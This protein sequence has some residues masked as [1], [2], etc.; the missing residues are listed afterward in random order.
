M[1]K[2]IQQLIEM[3]DRILTEDN[4]SDELIDQI[5]DYSAHFGKWY[6]VYKDSFVQDDDSNVAGELE[7]LLLKHEQV[8]GRVEDL[9]GQTSG[10][11]KEFRQ[12][13]KGILAY[14]DVL[15]KR[16]SFSKKRKG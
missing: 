12:R 5:A 1:L 16:I 15:P 13:A 2:N 9:Q 7:T 14:V 4:L 6:A 8:I 11:L 3:A 10:D